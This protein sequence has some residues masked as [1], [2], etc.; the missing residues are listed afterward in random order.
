MLAGSPRSLSG[1]RFDRRQVRRPVE[2]RPQQLVLGRQRAHVSSSSDLRGEVDL[3]LLDHGVAELADPVDL[4]AYRVA[5]LEQAVGERLAHGA[6]A[7]RGAGGDDVARLERERLG[8]VRHLLEAVVDHLAGVAVLAQLVV[9]VS[10][11]REVVRIAELLGRDQ[12]R[13]ERAVRVE[14]LAHRHGR[15]AHL[16]IAHGDVVGDRVA[17][18]HLVSALERNVPTPRAD[19][20]RQLTLIVEQV[21]DARHVDAVVWTDHA[22]DLLVEEDRELRRLHARLGDVV[23]VV[24]PDGQELPRPDRREQ[25]DLVEGILL[26]PVVAVDDVAVVYDSVPRAGAGIKATEPHRDTSGISTGACSG[27]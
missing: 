5:D 22:G 4:D 18:D 25:A 26:G 8:E 10:P 16:P 17:G 9:D 21:R 20:D 19:H 23:G 13:P 2:G 6:D 14:R 27:A 7:C 24:Q 3:R 11:D 1:T 12:P 15:R